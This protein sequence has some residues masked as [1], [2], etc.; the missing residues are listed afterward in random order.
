MS[1][2]VVGQRLRQMRIDANFSG[3]DFAAQLGW[4]ASKVTRIEQGQQTPSLYDIEQWCQ[5]CGQGEGEVT[6]LYNLLNTPTFEVQVAEGEPR[7]LGISITDATMTRLINWGSS[8]GYTVEEAI[9]VL[10]G[11]ANSGGH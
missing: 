8:R 7:L 6:V 4:H 3:K 5:G 10:L 2:L 9:S 11:H 1:K